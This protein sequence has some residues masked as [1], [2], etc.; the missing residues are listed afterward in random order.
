VRHLC[1]LSLLFIQLWAIDNPLDFEKGVCIECH[2]I[3]AQTLAQKYS[4]EQW[5]DIEE[6]LTLFVE[7]HK[8]A[9]SSLVYIKSEEF[10]KVFPEFINYMK[11][12]GN[13]TKK[14]RLR[15]N[16]TLFELQCT[17]NSINRTNFFFK[18][19]QKRLKEL[20]FAKN[21]TIRLIQGKAEVS[22]RDAFFKLFFI[23]TPMPTLMH[24]DM[25]LYFEESS[26]ST[27]TSV[28]SDKNESIEMKF[29]MILEELLKSSKILI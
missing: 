19:L 20:N 9:P 13:D 27:H 5:Q 16:K 22:T 2:N 1:F 10:K 3:D 8:E 15:D 29:D 4:K 6:D 28:N 7:A 24:W 14:I 11:L 25:S 26:Y 18:K 23:V 17:N 12:H 21:I